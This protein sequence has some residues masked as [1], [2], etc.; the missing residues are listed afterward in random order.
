MQFAIRGRKDKAIFFI[1]NFFF[2][3]FQLSCKK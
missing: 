3:F 2:I 1:P